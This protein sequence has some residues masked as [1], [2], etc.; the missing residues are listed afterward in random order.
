MPIWVRHNL[1]T[2]KD[3]H[4]SCLKQILAPQGEVGSLRGAHSRPRSLASQQ[5]RNGREEGDTGGKKEAGAGL[6]LSHQTKRVK[7]GGGDSNRT[8]EE[9]E[10]EEERSAPGWKS[11]KSVASGSSSNTVV[12]GQEKD[13]RRGLVESL[14]KG[15][16][17][18][19]ALEGQEEVSGEGKELSGQGCSQG[20]GLYLETGVGRVDLS[21]D[22]CQGCSTSQGYNCSYLVPLS[23][24]MPDS[25]V[26][27]LLP[28][29]ALP[30]SP[31][32]AGQPAFCPAVNEIEEQQ[33]EAHGSSLP[34]ASLPEGHRAVEVEVRTHSS[35]LLTY[36]VSSS[37]SPDLCALPPSEL[38]KVFSEIN[39]MVVRVCGE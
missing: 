24:H 35:F 22:Y 25:R 31:Q 33:E 6:P 34:P 36:R 8:V 38:G 5:P 21:T 20:H 29:S 12:T 27:L 30:C 11:S 26:R 14:V 7:E 10:E 3:I 4:L 15:L 19:R 13:S 17:R 2:S 28:A 1:I 9:E 32:S 37:P 18:K 16:R 23:A 39:V